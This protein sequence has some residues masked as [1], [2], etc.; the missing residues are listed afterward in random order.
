MRYSYG[1]LVAVSALSL[2]AYA[3]QAQTAPISLAPP[4]VTMYVGE[5]KT[6]QISGDGTIYYI[7]TN[8]RPDIA[9][10]FLKD[11]VLTVSAYYPGEGS[12]SVC[13][14]VQSALSCVNLNISVLKKT[15]EQKDKAATISFSK[16]NITIDINQ[17]VNLTVEGSRSGAYYMS[18]HSDP[19]V[20]YAGISGNI[21]TI[22]GTK[23]GG[24]N[25]TICQIGGTC[26][27]IY[28][29]VPMSAANKAAIQA[30]LPPTPVLSAF[31]VAS[32]N[33]GG[34]FASKGA[35]L[36][37]IFN[38]SDDITGK[39]LKIGGQEIAVT[40][41][42][43]GPYGG[44]YTVNGNEATPLPVSIE[45]STAKGMTGR[46][47]FT[48]GDKT[49]VLAPSVQSMLPSASPTSAIP[50]PSGLKR[51]TATLQLGSSG[52]EVSYLQSVLKQ[53]GVYDGPITGKFGNQTEAAVKKYQ[54]KVKLKPV[55]AVGP[56]TREML[57]KVI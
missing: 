13:S 41:T 55:G 22:K 18:A 57:N 12:V 6:V 45:F 33:V 24:S 48:I 36:T 5:M 21:V 27:N 31:Y 42:G 4:H 52:I 39:T 28:A 1:I 26:G 20:V 10:A 53:L 47:F 29:F 56:A 11:G 7:G 17:T 35:V 37:I 50:S 3:V 16:S 15:D 14:Y 51:F 30:T 32:N 38:T 54:S 40:G 44:S 25:I 46:S 19:E 2:G 43:S 9:G 8:G 49:S 23:I 34:G